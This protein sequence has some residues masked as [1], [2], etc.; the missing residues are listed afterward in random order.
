[1]KKQIQKYA[2]K[3]IEDG[4]YLKVTLGHRGLRWNTKIAGGKKKEHHTE[5]CSE[6]IFVFFS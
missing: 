3:H 5:T 4:C 1:M 6:S 2:R